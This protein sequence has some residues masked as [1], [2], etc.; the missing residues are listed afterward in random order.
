MYCIIYHKY[1]LYIYASC[2]SLCIYIY[3]AQKD[4]KAF[5]LVTSKAVP[6]DEAEPGT[7]PLGA[8]KS[9]APRCQLRRA[10]GDRVGRASTSPS[11]WR[12]GCEVMKP[13]LEIAILGL[14]L[15]ANDFQ[16]SP[17]MIHIRLYLLAGLGR[18]LFLGSRRDSKPKAHSRHVSH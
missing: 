8:K 15:T 18:S 4:R 12:A 16:L 7:F 3:H 6:H 2:A 11:D 9:F 14:A 5:R 13:S 1:Y 10:S 17:F